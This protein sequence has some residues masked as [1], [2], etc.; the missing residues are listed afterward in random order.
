[1]ILTL[2]ISLLIAV[3]TE[4]TFAAMPVLESVSNSYMASPVNTV[5]CCHN[6]HL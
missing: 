3:L 2:R 5:I 4:G 1:M 6:I